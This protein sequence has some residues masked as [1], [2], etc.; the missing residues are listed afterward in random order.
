[1][2]RDGDLMIRTLLA[3]AEKARFWKR[4]TERRA[5]NIAMDLE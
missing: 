1:M 5:A 3:E 2:K 4:L